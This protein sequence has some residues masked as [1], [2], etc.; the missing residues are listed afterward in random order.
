MV[1][2]ELSTVDARRLLA[3]LI[4]DRNDYV[5][6]INHLKKMDPDSVVGKRNQTPEQAIKTTEQAIKTIDRVMAQLRE[7]KD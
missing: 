3:I 6:G 4:G 2:L 5:D 1:N 7:K